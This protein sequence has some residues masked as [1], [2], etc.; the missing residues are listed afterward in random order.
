MCNE[1]SHILVDELFVIWTGG[2]DYA[3]FEPQQD[4]DPDNRA[5]PAARA[6]HTRSEPAGIS[7]FKDLLT[8]RTGQRMQSR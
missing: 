4:V 3:I 1:L 8:A 2:V 6:A 5:T 7:L